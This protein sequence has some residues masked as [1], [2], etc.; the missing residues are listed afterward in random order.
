VVA[1]IV[2]LF[3]AEVCAEQCKLLSSNVGVNRYLLTQK[4]IVNRWV[5]FW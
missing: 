1:F 3:G 5:G 2:W 4:M